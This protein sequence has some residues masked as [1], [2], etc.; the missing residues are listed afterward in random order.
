[1]RFSLRDD[2][3]T[4][5]TT[6]LKIDLGI[7]REPPKDPF[8]MLER[9]GATVIGGV[10]L[11]DGTLEAYKEMNEEQRK[12]MIDDLVELMESENEDETEPE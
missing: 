4:T 7:K 10:M 3:S 5:N 6:P 9:M 8:E 11:P 1:M 12:E 2:T